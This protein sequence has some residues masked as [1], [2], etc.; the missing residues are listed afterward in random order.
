MHSHWLES[1]KGDPESLYL[2]LLIR[3]QTNFFYH[4]KQHIP[5]MV[6]DH[7]FSYWAREKGRFNDSLLPGRPIYVFVDDLRQPKLNISYRDT[8][9]LY[10]NF[11]DSLETRA[12]YELLLRKSNPGTGQAE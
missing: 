6:R 11:A 3:S 10:L 4:E 9:V 7:G 2:M 5:Q 12:M 8:L 1:R